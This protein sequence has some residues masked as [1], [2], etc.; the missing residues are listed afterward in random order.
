MWKMD[1][2]TIHLWGNESDRVQLEKDQK[3]VE[4][5]RKKL[6]D[7]RALPATS[8]KA[9]AEIIAAAEM[10]LSQARK[11][12]ISLTEAIPEIKSRALKISNLRVL[13]SGVLA[14]DVAQRSYRWLAQDANPTLDSIPQG[15]SDDAKVYMGNGVKEISHKSGPDNGPAR[16]QDR[17]SPT[18]GGAAK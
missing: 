1:K 14:F 9:K 18:Q 8:D 17:T 4:E 11:E 10:K 6:T 2:D 15:S 7:V 5:L 16:S 13:A 3:R 12:A